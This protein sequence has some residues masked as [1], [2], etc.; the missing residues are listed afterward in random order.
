M[1]ERE[2]VADRHAAAE[3]PVSVQV[4]VGAV[5]DRRTVDSKIGPVGALERIVAERKERAHRLIVPRK[6]N[7]AARV[8]AKRCGIAEARVGIEDDLS[9]LSEPRLARVCIFIPCKRYRALADG[10][11]EDDVAGRAAVRTVLDEC[12]KDGRLVRCRIGRDGKTLPARII[13]V[14]AAVDVAGFVEQTKIGDLVADRKRAGL[15]VV[16]EVLVVL[17]NGFGNTPVFGAAVRQDDFLLN[18]LRGPVRRTFGVEIVAADNRRTAH[19]FGCIAVHK[20]EIADAGDD[21]DVR[22]DRAGVENFRAAVGN[23]DGIVRRAE[24]NGGLPV[25]SSSRGVLKRQCARTEIDRRV[26]STLAGNIADR[27]GFNRAAR[28][29]EAAELAFVRSTR[30]GAVAHEVDHAVV[31]KDERRLCK[32]IAAPV[33]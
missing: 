12:V 15:A 29:G 11:L 24:D 26:E 14:V 9:I 10:A 2:L 28:H 4:S 7:G 16:R 13:G 8:Y 27:A 20:N 5:D 3:R 21:S 32:R 22:A 1:A 33:G 19:G 31:V 17:A 6:V 23:L 18:F 25:I 30:S